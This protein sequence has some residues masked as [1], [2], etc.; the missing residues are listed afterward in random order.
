[1][2][3]AKIFVAIAAVAASVFAADNIDWTSDATLACTKTNWAAIKKASDPMLGMA[4]TILSP[5]QAAALSSL[6]GGAST[7]PADPSDDFLHALPNAIPGSVLNL[8][9]G[10]IVSACLKTY[11]APTATPTGAPASSDAPAPASSDAPATTDAPAPTDAP[12]SSDDG[13]GSTEEPAASS[14]PAKC[15]PRA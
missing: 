1:M 5:D 7:M 11:E 8:I 3:F 12:A 15:K 13:A 10:D 14:A 9:A 2:Q 6:L 4:G